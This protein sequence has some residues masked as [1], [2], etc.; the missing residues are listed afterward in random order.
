M[1][2]LYIDGDLSPWGE[3]DPKERVKMSKE[4]VLGQKAA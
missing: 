4:G 1:L 3:W 2:S